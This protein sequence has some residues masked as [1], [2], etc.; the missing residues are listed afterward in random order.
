MKGAESTRLSIRMRGGSLGH[1]QALEKEERFSSW[2]N[3]EFSRLVWT[4]GAMAAEHVFYGENA[5]GVGGD[6]H[7]ATTRAGY[8][9]GVAGMGPTQPELDGGFKSDGERDRARMRMMKRFEEV[10]NQL[11]NRSGAGGPADVEHNP[12]GAVLGDRYKR[13]L[14]AQ[15]LGQAYVESYHLV[16]HN[17]EAV[18]RIADTLV[19]RKELYGNELLAL[20]DSQKL[21]RPEID[22][23]SEEAWPTL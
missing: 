12:I 22:L 20:L 1:H 15:I 10:G 9:V 11:M 8:M 13:A 7:S 4:L 2:R 16:R 6:L 18:E 14:A 19:E 17:R 23:T 3:E 5:T 21:Q